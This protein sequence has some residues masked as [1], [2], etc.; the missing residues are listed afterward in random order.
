MSACS[1]GVSAGFSDCCAWRT[2]AI[3]NPMTNPVKA[4]RTNIVRAPSPQ[5]PRAQRIHRSQSAVGLWILSHGRK[6]ESK[7]HDPAPILEDPPKG[8]LDEH[9]VDQA[10]Q[11]PQ[12][13]CIEDV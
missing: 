4:S 5:L 9:P 13:R 12:R 10:T 7:R 11:D 6:S 2:P 1:C 8:T 3:D